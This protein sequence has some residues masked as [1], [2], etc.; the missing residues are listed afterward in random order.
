MVITRRLVLQ[1]A[2]AVW[3]C[4]RSYN[5][6]SVGS[7]VKCGTEPPVIGNVEHDVLYIPVAREFPVVDAFYFVKSLTGNAVGVDAVADAGAGEHW[8]LVCVQVT[9]QSKHGTTY[10]ANDFMSRMA[11]LFNGWAQ[12]RDSL[13]LEIIYAQHVDSKPITRWQRCKTSKQ[14]TAIELQAALALRGRCE[15]YRVLLDKDICTALPSYG[16]RK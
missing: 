6:L 8:T 2:R 14:C 7:R 5:V 11:Q 10:A 9:R 15:Q 4:P 3:S 13:A 1:S 12:L 16:K